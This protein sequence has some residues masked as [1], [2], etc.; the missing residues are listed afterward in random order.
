MKNSVKNIEELDEYL[1]HIKEFYTR[2]SIKKE[3]IKQELK[4]NS[5]KL[6][7]LIKDIDILEKV[8]ILLQK[9]S[10][11]AREQSKKQIE[12]LVTNC[13]KYIF[14]SDIEFKIEIEELYGKPNAEFYVISKY[15][16]ETIETKP[17]LSRGGGVIDIISLALRI[18]F[19]QIHKPNVEGPIILDEPAKH[20]SQDYI[21]N[22]A[23]FLKEISEMFNRQ[24]IM[25]THNVHL[26]SISP[27]SYRVEL[28]G[29]ES[30]V[31]TME[32]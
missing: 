19:L 31:S 7:V 27:N 24:I 22:V 16:D 1:V 26:A 12:K 18:A 30:I 9:T 17:E 20:V 11:Y 21:F 5:K 2:E 10:E 25:V 3:R 28:K 8:N 32:P 6:K 15:E 23:N 13:L 29:S 4:E 14:E